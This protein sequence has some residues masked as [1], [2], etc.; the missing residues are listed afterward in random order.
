MIH[1]HQNGIESNKKWEINDEV[2]GNGKISN[3]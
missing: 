1:H 3:G 2:H